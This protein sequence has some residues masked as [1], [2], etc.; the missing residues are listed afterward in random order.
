[1]IGGFDL[2][3]FGMAGVKRARCHHH[4]GH[5]DETGNAQC[6]HDFL[7]GKTEQHAAF[8]VIADRHPS[9]RQS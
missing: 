1:M 8:F 6:N 3:H 5:V 9:L 2:R 4:H 7:V